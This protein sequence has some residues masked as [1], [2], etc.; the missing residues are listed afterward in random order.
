MTTEPHVAAMTAALSTVAP[1]QDLRLR[2]WRSI[3][4][5]GDRYI[6]TFDREV[7]IEPEALWPTVEAAL[8]GERLV[9][10][11]QCGPDSV[12]IMTMPIRSAAV[13]A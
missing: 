11:M 7:V 10:I 6:A 4:Y 8:I 2:A 13:A 5:S 1:V 12:E 9:D 3:T